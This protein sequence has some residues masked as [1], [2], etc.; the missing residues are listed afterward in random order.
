MGLMVERW[1]NR[2][3]RGG[4]PVVRLLYLL[5]SRLMKPSANQ[6]PTGTAYLEAVQITQ[7]GFEFRKENKGAM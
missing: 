5:F 4:F 3:E 1:G 6:G 2:Y 7:L